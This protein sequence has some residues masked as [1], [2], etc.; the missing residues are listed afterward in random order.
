MQLAKLSGATPHALSLPLRFGLWAQSGERNIFHNPTQALKKVYWAAK[1]ESG[2]DT[3]RCVPGPGV[4]KTM[5]GASGPM[6]LME[7]REAFVTT[8]MRW[9]VKDLRESPSYPFT[10]SLMVIDTAVTLCMKG[11]NHYKH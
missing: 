11:Y 7:I 9:N 6:T 10:Y 1:G 8:V 2:W 4:P 3:L 5:I